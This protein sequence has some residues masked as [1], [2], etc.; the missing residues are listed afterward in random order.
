MITINVLLF[1]DKEPD[2]EKIK[3]NVLLLKIA[4]A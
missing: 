2:E 4:V 3:V 1:I